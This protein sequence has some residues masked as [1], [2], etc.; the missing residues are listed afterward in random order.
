MSKPLHLRDQL[1][2]IPVFPEDH[3]PEDSIPDWDENTEEL[4]PLLDDDDD[5]LLPNPTRDALQAL[6]RQ[7]LRVLP[8]LKTTLGAV[9]SAK[10][11]DDTPLLDDEPTDESRALERDYRI[12][13]RAEITTDA[14]VVLSKLQSARALGKLYVPLMAQAAIIRENAQR[15]ASALLMFDDVVPM[16]YIRL[17]RTEIDAFRTLFKAWVASF[18]PDEYPDDWGLFR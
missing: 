1:K 16:E 6:T 17:V 14:L 10:L 13:V 18:L 12:H 3:N 5:P 4:R 15:V 9:G 11:P 7:W 2:S 8:L